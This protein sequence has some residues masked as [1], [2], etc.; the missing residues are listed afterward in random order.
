MVIR[1]ERRLRAVVDSERIIVGPEKAKEGAEG[2]RSIRPVAALVQEYVLPQVH[3]PQRADLPESEAIIKVGDKVK[4]AQIIADG[5]ATHQGECRCGRNVLVA[6]M[7]WD[8]YNFEVLDHHQRK[9]R[10]E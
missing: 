10:E 8:G 1:T 3:R 6:F 9:P 2:S 7:S 5:A 4:K